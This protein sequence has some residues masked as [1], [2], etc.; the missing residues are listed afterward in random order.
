VRN[1]IK[2]GTVIY[3]SYRDVAPE[4]WRW[5]NFSPDEPNLYCPC[6][7]EFFLDF[8]SMD[9]IQRARSEL[10]KSIRINSAHSCGI[11]NA[12]VGGAPLSQHK[13]IAFDVSVTGVDYTGI[14]SSF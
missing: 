14:I 8:P 4:I 2:G 6:C 3:D 11:H 1:A 9:M 5:D 13:K 7:G 10:G 12:R